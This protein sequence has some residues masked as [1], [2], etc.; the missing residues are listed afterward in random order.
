MS[1]WNS[2]AAT[3]FLAL[4]GAPGGGP[5]TAAGYWPGVGHPRFIYVTGDMH[6]FPSLAPGRDPGGRFGA[7][8]FTLESLAGQAARAVNEGRGQSLVWM[9]VGANASYQT[10]LAGVLRLTRARR[11]E[12]TDP[13]ALVKT[14]ARQGVIKGYVLYRADPS[15]RRPYEA[16][17]E[18]QPGYSNSANVATTV[19]SLCSGVIVEEAA[20]PVFRAMGLRCLEDVRD[21]DEEWLFATYRHRCNRRLVHV[22][23]PKAPDD[24]GY[25]ILTQSLCVFGVTPF[26]ERVYAWLKPNSPVVGWNAGDEYRAVS[27]MSRWGKFLTASNWCSN[28][29]VTSA[30]RA[31]QDVPWPSLQVNRQSDVDPLSLTWETDRHYTAFVL[32]DGDNLQ[33]QMGNFTHHAWY[34]GAPTRGRFPFGWTACLA[35]LSQVAVPTLQYMAT[36]ATANDTAILAEAGYF[37]AD[38]YGARLADPGRAIEEHMDQVAAT[39]AQ[40]GIHVLELITG[41]DCRSP[42]A[43]EAYRRIARRLRGLDGILVI[44]YAPYNGGQGEIMWVENREHETIPVIPARYCLWAKL[45][46]PGCGPPAEVAQAINRAE[47]AGPVTGDGFLDWTI[48]HAWSRFRQADTTAN[49]RA[50]EVD[51]ADPAQVADAKAGYEPVGWCIQRLEPQVRVVSPQELVWRTRLYLRTRETL[52]ALARRAGQEDYLRWL[53]AAPLTTDTERRAAFERLRALGPGPT[54][55]P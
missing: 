11:V 19:A 46:R 27:P 34:W 15:D 40:L 54:P 25:A 49:L 43:Q 44:Q 41:G 24:R 28:L 14:F 35:D 17:P 52:Q 6:G 18:R 39:M 13:L 5:A 3:A 31:G 16:Q 45:R 4:S 12:V 1:G 22:L 37:Y 2:L 23:D 7:L 30:V 10:W 8:A 33:W 38:E 42:A 21:R 53:E 51:E 26:T 36:T 55:A 29:T 50:E 48:V 32:S 47:H 9:G 20:E